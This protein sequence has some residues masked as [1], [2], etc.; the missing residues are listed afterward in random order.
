MEF[1]LAKPTDVTVLAQSRIPE[2]YGDYEKIFITSDI[3]DYHILRILKGFGQDYNP[4]ENKVILEHQIIPKS[5]TEGIHTLEI[6]RKIL[7]QDDGENYN[8]IVKDTVEECI[9]ILNHR[10]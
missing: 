9:Q 2:M 1:Q 3:N 10:F 6:L 4:N 7:D 5:K 8:Y